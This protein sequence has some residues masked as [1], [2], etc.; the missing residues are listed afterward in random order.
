MSDKAKLI[1]QAAL[2]NTSGLL[3]KNIKLEI[4][5]G[6]CYLTAAVMDGRLV[7]VNLTVSRI[8]GDAS[9]MLLSHQTAVLEA[10]KLDVTK[11]LV[12]RV[13]RDASELLQRGEWGAMDLIM[14]W[15]GTRF[16][17]EGYCRQ[18]NSL[19]ASPLDAA[20]QWLDFKVKGGEL[21]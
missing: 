19:V 10:S 21:R 20:A 12:E 9:D 8:G 15:R 6:D 2:E 18:V 7:Y 11:A 5:T 1:V 17:P 3:G 16:D 14:A 4:G 13:C